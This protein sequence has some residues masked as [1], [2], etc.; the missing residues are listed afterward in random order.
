[1]RLLAKHG[2]DTRVVHESNYV[3][4]EGYQRRRERTTAVMAALGMG[5]GIAWIPVDRAERDALLLETV[6]LAVELGADV[7]VANI[8]GRTALDSARAQKQTA[9]VE[10]LESRG[11][12]GKPVTPSAPA[13]TKPTP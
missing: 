11:A 6:K 12:M 4:G 3:Q 2:A 9:I 1:M 5:G 10:F 8:D 13:G 7:N